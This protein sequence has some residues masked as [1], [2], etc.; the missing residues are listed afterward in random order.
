MCCIEVIFWINQPNDYTVRH[1][2]SSFASNCHYSFPIPVHNLFCCCC[3]W[4]FRI[5]VF[6]CI[7]H[8]NRMRSMFS[9]DSHKNGVSRKFKL[10]QKSKPIS[11]IWWTTKR[12]QLNEKKTTNNHWILDFAGYSLFC[13]KLQEF[14]VECQRL[15]IFN[16]RLWFH[17]NNICESHSIFSRRWTQKT[18]KPRNNQPLI[19]RATIS[20]SHIRFATEW[21]RER[22]TEHR[23]KLTHFAWFIFTPNFTRSHSCMRGSI[24]SW[25]FLHN[26]AIYI[27]IRVGYGSTA[28]F[29]IHF[30]Y[31]WNFCHLHIHKLPHKS[32]LL[33]L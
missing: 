4:I 8:W 32:R 27:Y 3:C 19:K 6:I 24:F 14:A 7:C 22:D 10:R 21:K 2:H 9:A 12:Q 20:I 1:S 23:S 11:N 17:L 31:K 30:I 28:K 25:S 5:L 26:S 13:T 15:R 29:H 33:F 16:I 18:H